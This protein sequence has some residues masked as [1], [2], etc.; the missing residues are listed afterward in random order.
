MTTTRTH[1][2]FRVDTWTA[3]GE[4]ISALERG[5]GALE[6]SSAA[7]ENAASPPQSCA[8]A[9]RVGVGPAETTRHELAPVHSVTSSAPAARR[10]LVVHALGRPVPCM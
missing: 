3:D 6:G 8:I 10:H 5:G 9:S 2:T 7:C 1:F 4:S